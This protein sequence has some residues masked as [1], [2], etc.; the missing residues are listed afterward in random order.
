MDVGQLQKK[1]ATAEY[2]QLCYR[3]RFEEDVL[4]PPFAL[5]RLRREFT[6]VIKSG[7]FL[8]E[9]VSDFRTL[10][11]PPLPV[12][13]G[14]LRR[15]QQPSPGFVLQIEQLQKQVFRRGESLDLAV[16]FAGQGIFQ[17]GIFSRLLSTLGKVGI[18]GCAGRFELETIESSNLGSVPDT[19][20]TSGPFLLIPQVFDLAPVVSAG[21]PEAVTLEFLTPARLLVKSRP[22]FNASFKEIFPFVLRRVTAMLAAWMYLEDVF[23]IRYLL[24]SAMQITES[25]LQLHWQDWRPLDK[26]D[27]AGGLTGSVRLEGPELID[28]WPVLK[29]GEIWGIGKGAAYGAGRYRLK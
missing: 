2:L 3:L 29:L 21:V 25:E 18:Y 7:M 26:K 28:L 19:L 11:Q 27:E 14:V 22:L 15:V 17:T 13:P 8:T 16:V 20:W 5:L 6:R 4:L 9:D 1:L 12:D 10:L 23:E 24:D